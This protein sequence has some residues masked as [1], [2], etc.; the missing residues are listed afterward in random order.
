MARRT[1][2]PGM[3]SRRTS[4]ACSLMSIPATFSAPSSSASQRTLPPRLQ[5]TSSAEPNRS[6]SSSPAQNGRRPSPAA[7]VAVD[8]VVAEVAGPQRLEAG[9]VAI[10]LLH[11]SASRR[12]TVPRPMSEIPLQH[13]C[14]RCVYPSAAA[15][16]AIFDDDGRLLRLPRQR[17]Q[18]DASTGPTGARSC[19]EILEEYRSTR[20]LQ[21]RLP[22][23]RLGRQG[24]ALPDLRDHA[25]VRAPPAAG[26]LSR[27]Q[28]PAGRPAQPAQPARALRLRPRLLLART[29]RRSRSSTGCASG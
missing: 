5:P 4:S 20:R 1:S 13:Y 6:R 12:A 7:R 26:D 14:T 16:A 18:A 11:W 24:L 21:L 17:R 2:T 3:F 23:P 22:D 27:Q 29:S 15:A 28:L 8:V 19:G 10:V 9:C 25:G